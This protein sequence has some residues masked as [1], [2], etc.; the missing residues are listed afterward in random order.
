MAQKVIGFLASP[1]RRG[2]TETLLDK[3]LEGA[4]SRGAEV[5]K[6]VLRELTFCPCI[7]CGECDKTGI[8]T[9]ND[10]FQ[11]LYSQLKNN[12]IFIFASPLYFAGVS[13]FGKVLIDRCQAMWVAKYRLRKPIAPKSPMRRGILIASRGMPGIEGFQ[14]IKAE[15]KS[16]FSVNNIVYFDEVLVGDCDGKGH[17]KGRPELL[18]LAYTSGQRLIAN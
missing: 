16:F 2:N 18:E 17:V 14:T 9:I 11:T 10:D 6:V 1:R 3:A 7:A 15:V 13:A 12:S 5:E 4:Q 8:C